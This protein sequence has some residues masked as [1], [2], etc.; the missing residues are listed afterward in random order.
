MVRVFNPQASRH[1]AA[2][3]KLAR[4]AAGGAWV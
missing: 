1:D 4:A 2:H 3:D